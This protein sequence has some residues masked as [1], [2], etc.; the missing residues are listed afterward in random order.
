VEL[1][2][3]VFNTLCINMGTSW[4]KLFFSWEKLL[5]KR[6]KKG[7]SLERGSFCCNSLLKTIKK[8]KIFKK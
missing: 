7:E 6:V 1:L 2:G 5:G 4:E 3:L 8:C